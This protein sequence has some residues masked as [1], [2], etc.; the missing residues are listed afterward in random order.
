M[1]AELTDDR[2][3]KLLRV[4]ALRESIGWRVPRWARWD[5]GYEWS[6]HEMPLPNVQAIELAQL[7]AELAGPG[8]GN[9][10]GSRLQ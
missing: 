6:G 10:T 1:H 3:R 5:I 7:I 2:T 8:G 4:A 9:E